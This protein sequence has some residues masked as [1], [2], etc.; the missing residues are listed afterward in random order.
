MD[1]FDQIYPC[2]NDAVRKSDLN[3]HFRRRLVSM[4]FIKQMKKLKAEQE[5]QA[6]RL[7]VL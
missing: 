3:R 6:R 4:R 2:V 5:A 7:A 1:N